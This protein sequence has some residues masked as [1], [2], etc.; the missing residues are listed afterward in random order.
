[1]QLYSVSPT[2]VIRQMLGRQ[3]SVH[4][5]RAF[6]AGVLG[7]PAKAEEVQ[8]EVRAATPTHENSNAPNACPDLARATSLVGGENLRRGASS[9]IV[10]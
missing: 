3:S 5:S 6:A 4:L 8:D 7:S 9:K 10:Y 1:M 2:K